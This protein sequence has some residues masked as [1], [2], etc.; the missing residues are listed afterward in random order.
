MAFDLVTGK[1]VLL[2]GGKVFEKQPC[3]YLK[4]WM[5]SIGLVIVRNTKSSIN[6]NRKFFIVKIKHQRS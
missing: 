5:D 2:T 4:V 6:D 3:S 1:F